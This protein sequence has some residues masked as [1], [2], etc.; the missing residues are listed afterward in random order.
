MNYLPEIIN[1][2]NNCEIAGIATGLSHTLAWDKSGRIY[3]WGDSANGKLGYNM[4]NSESDGMNL[5]YT[6][7][8]V[9]SL[10]NIFVIKGACANSYSLALTPQGEL[11]AWGKGE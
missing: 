7:R 10:N 9:I 5:Q 6:P 4:L 1:F 3:S 11:F 2:G 8:Q